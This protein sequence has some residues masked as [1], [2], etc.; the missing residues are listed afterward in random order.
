MNSH[1]ST[2]KER[3]ERLVNGLWGIKNASILSFLDAVLKGGMQK[4]R[5]YYLVK[6][7]ISVEG[8]MLKI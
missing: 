2:C 7:Y 4:F 3:R 1:E 8:V 5:K 6:L